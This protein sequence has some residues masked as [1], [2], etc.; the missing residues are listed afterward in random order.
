[1]KVVLCTAPVEAAESLAS[2]LVGERVAACVNVLQGVRSVYRWEGRVDTADEV[3]LVIKTSDDSLPALMARVAELHPY[4]VPEI[5]AL[6]TCDVHPP[7]ALWVDG[8]TGSAK[9]P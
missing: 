1:M 9:A 2:S 7:Y 8:S 4:D 5:V 6:D 3:L